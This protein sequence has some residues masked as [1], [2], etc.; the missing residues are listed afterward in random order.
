[1]TGE[2]AEAARC[3]LARGHR[4][5]GIGDLLKAVSPQTPQGAHR[6]DWESLEKVS[7]TVQN[8]GRETQES[9]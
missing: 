1:M 2:S 9:A 4:Y 5:G 7:F 6:I 8:W 3:M